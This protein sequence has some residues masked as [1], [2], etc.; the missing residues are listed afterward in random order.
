MKKQQEDLESD[1]ELYA[2]YDAYKA[3]I[4]AGVSQK[5]ALKRSGLTPQILK[6]L[7]EE[8]EDEELKDDFKEVYD[9]DEDSDL[10]ESDWKEDSGFSED[11][12][13][14]EDGIAD[15]SSWD[16]KDF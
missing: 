13:E 15:D 1:D 6:D 3:L 8:E 9:E 2:N 5:E 11:D 7:E 10:N 16:D 14:W 4:E 12:D